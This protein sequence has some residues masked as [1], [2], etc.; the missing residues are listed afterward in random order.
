MTLYRVKQFYWS[1]TCKVNTEDE[2]FIKNYMNEQEMFLFEKLPDYEKIHALKVA[3]DIKKTYSGNEENKYMLIKAALLHDI[4]KISYRLNPI[5][6]SLMVIFDSISR[7]SIKKYSNIKK[8]NVYYNHADMGYSMLKE[9]GYKE[10]FLY[11]IKNHHNNNII[12]DKE[13]DILKEC[14]SRN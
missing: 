4:G 9:Y 2:N 13:L 5:Y 14:D 12:G 10:R 1:I 11:L 7:G 6:K 8:I 3:K